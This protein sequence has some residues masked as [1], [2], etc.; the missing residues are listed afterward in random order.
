MWFMALLVGFLIGL[1]TDIWIKE[2]YK[3]DN[4]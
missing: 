4:K 1:V 3:D 2:W